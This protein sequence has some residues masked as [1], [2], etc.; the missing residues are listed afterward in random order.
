M[1][2]KHS[3]CIAFAKSCENLFDQIDPATLIHTMDDLLK[4]AF[5]DRRNAELLPNE[6]ESLMDDILTIKNFLMDIGMQHTLNQLHANALQQAQSE[7]NP[8]NQ[9]LDALFPYSATASA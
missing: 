9:V 8:L 7:A 1:S 3:N 6:R 5:A 4:S 2:V